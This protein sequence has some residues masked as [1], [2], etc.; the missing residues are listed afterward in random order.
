M[1]EEPNAFNYPVEICDMTWFAQVGLLLKNWEDGDTWV[2]Y[3][4]DQGIVTIHSFNSYDKLSEPFISTVY[5]PMTLRRD[6]RDWLVEKNWPYEIGRTPSN[7]N[8][9]CRGTVKFTDPSHALIFK[10]T[11]Y[12]NG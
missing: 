8:C 11:W 7:W 10:L 1:S 2:K 12:D 6:V 5:G 4:K 3:P 9:E